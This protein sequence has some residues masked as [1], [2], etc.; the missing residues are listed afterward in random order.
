MQ[1]FVARLRKMIGD[2]VDT[3]SQA[4]LPFLV[5]ICVLGLAGIAIAQLPPVPVPPQNPITEQ[6]RIL[7]KLLF[8]EEQLSSDNSVSCGT[9]HIPSHAGAD[10]RIG[11]NPGFD[12]LFGTPDD[13]FG[14]PGVARADA[15]NDPV[16]DPA[17]GFEPQTT[18]RSAQSVFG[19]LWS[20]LGFWDGR[21]NGTFV[22]PQTGAVSIPLGGALESQAVGPILS[23][24]EMA[25][26]SRDW[27]EVVAKLEAVAPLT[28]ATHLP[29]DMVT[30]LSADPTYSDLFDA[31]FG[32]PTI[33][34][35]RIAFA[36]AT[37]ERTLVPDQS[38]WDAF[39]A[40]SP[41]ALTPGQQAGW[42]F[43]QGSACRLC[44][45]PPLF[46]NSTFR[47]IGLRPPF[48]DTGRAEVTGLPPDRGRFK[49]PT[50]RNVGLKSTFMHNARLFSLNEVLDFYLG[51]NGQVQFPGNQDP[52][53]GGIAIPPPVR[54]ALLDF[55]A[56]GLT[57]PRVAAQVFPFDRPILRSELGD[58]DANGNVNLADFA[59]FNACETEPGELAV[60]ECFV[61]D[62]DNDNDVDF[63]DFAGFQVR[64]DD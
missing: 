28:L 34:A 31:A 60:A 29:P 17:F 55:M 53:I 56:N 58:G 42:N 24:V 59:T 36:I 62:F 25:H 10:P 41:N 5:A 7:G 8:W 47:N 26:E 19:A 57:D 4:C 46:T 11:W 18:G 64:F 2:T 63:A 51:I 44:H 13:V 22:D 49:V 20:P 14:S 9:C 16:F 6:K 40:G 50:L 35:E 23:D 61:F 43:F 45:T 39:V 27:D 33:T 37:Y 21:A 48:E 3:N 52:L 1:Q 54:P 30:A 38:P 12:G 32:D 15:N